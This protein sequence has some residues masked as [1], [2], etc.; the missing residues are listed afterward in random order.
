MSREG[1]GGESESSSDGDDEANHFEGLE[2]SGKSRESERKEI[3]RE[4]EKRENGG[5]EQV[6]KELT[7][8]F[9]PF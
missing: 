7:P 5:K 4:R 6:E 1:A 8:S 3:E 2:E 9:I